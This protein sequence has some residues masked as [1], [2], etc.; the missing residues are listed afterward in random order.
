MEKRRQFLKFLVGGAALVGTG[1]GSFFSMAKWVLAQ[2]EKILLPKGTRFS[3]SGRG[4]R[5]LRL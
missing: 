2:T 5:L 4:R 1:I 3:P